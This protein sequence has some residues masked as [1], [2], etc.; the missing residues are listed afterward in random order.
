MKAYKRRFIQE[1]N[2]VNYRF[3]KLD[4]MLHQYKLNKLDFEPKCSYD[5]LVE[6][7]DAMERYLDCLKD[8]AI[9]EGIEL[10]Y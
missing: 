10:E 5:L 3:K 4:K 7:R 6:Q 8:R 2:E 1:F 9:I